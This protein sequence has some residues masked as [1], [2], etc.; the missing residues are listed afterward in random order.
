MYPY[1]PSDLDPNN[2]ASDY[3]AMLNLLSKTN[4]DLG[5][6]NIA[7]GEVMPGSGKDTELVTLNKAHPILDTQICAT[8]T[9]H[10]VI[11][12]NIDPRLLRPYL[13]YRPLQVV[14]NTL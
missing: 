12:E 3:P 6:N 10:I 9:W 1:D 11:Y 7:S 5:E 13:S 2:E 14:K 4:E 8:S